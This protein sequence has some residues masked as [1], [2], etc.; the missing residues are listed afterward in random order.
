MGKPAPGWVAVIP[1]RL[2]G[3]PCPPQLR[4]T[5]AFRSPRAARGHLPVF[6]SLSRL[7]GLLPLS[8]KAVHTGHRLSL[9]ARVALRPA[10]ASTLQGRPCSQGLCTQVA[11][12]LSHGGSTLSGLSGWPWV[13]KSKYIPCNTWDILIL[14]GL[15]FL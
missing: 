6:P 11:M 5:V 13:L 3:W 8:L 2:A 7:Q 1:R 9:V 10:A 4:T 14:K 12:Q 15:W